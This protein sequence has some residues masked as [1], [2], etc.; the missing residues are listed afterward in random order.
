[1]RQILTDF[2]EQFTYK[3]RESLAIATAVGV[4]SVSPP[5]AAAQTTINTTNTINNI[6]ITTNHKP[7]PP[8]STTT[9]PTYYRES[10]PSPARPAARTCSSAPKLQ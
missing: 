10:S 4:E 9:K 8:Q 7:P 2:V 1:M 5:L 3:R 6:R